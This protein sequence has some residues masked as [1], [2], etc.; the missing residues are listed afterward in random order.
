MNYVQKL[1]IA[2]LMVV[3]GGCAGGASMPSEP[4]SVNVTGKWAGTWSFQNPSMGGGQVTMD[5]K[6]DGAKVTGPMSVSGPT[7]SEPTN[8]A[9]TVS[10]STIT[11]D[12]AHG[13]GTLAVKG[14]EMTGRVYGIMPARVSL[15]R[16]R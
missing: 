7:S 15:K 9:G 4:P 16:Q 8:F 11:L 10:G 6:Q 2:G 13:S 14:D 3:I 5:L 1:L 12:A